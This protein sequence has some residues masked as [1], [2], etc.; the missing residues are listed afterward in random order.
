[1]G[2]QIYLLTRKNNMRIFNQ[3]QSPQ[4]AGYAWLGALQKMGQEIDYNAI[5]Q[6]LQVLRP[7]LAYPWHTLKFFQN[8]GIVD[9]FEPVTD[10]QAIACLRRGIPIVTGTA[11]WGGID[12]NNFIKF[13]DPNEPI[14][15]DKPYAWTTGH[16]FVAV[17]LAEEKGKNIVK[18]QNS[19]GENWGDGG[20]FYG[21]ISDPRLLRLIYLIPTNSPYASNSATA[22]HNDIIREWNGKRIDYDGAYGYQCVDWVRKYSTLRGRYIPVFGNAFALWG[23]N[24]GSHWQKIQYDGHNAPQE[25]DIIIWDKSWGGGFGHIAVANAYCDEKNLRY[26]D[27]NGGRGSAKGIG[28]D[29]ITNRFG[30]Y[31]GVVGWFRWVG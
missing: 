25:G 21:D 17:E 15:P 28:V 11:S 7:P 29:A 27:Q 6:E 26:T 12:E 13:R 23:K 1:M 2:N 30:D 4:C 8:K 3:G 18:F 5:D 14:P 9:R 16:D 22:K 24:W 31:R 20:Y 10:N 19:W